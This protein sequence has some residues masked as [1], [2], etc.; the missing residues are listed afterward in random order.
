M[1]TPPVRVLIVDDSATIRRLLRATIAT[2][3]RLEVVG[4]ASDPYEARELIKALDPDVLTLDVEM[5][6]MNGLDFLEKLMRLRPMPVVVVSTRTRDKTAEAL[7]ALALGAVDSVDVSRLQV[8]VGVRRR[9]LGTL[10]AAGS[11]SVHN[12]GAARGS[13][14]TPAPEPGF[15]WN[16]LAVAIGSSTGGVDALERVLGNFPADCPPTLIAQHMPAPFLESFARRLDGLVAPTVAIAQAGEELRPG[17]VLLSGGGT[18]HL[19][20]AGGQPA[21]A[22]VPSDPD[23][24]YVPSIDRLFHS[25]AALGRRAVGVILTGMGRDGAEGL[26]AMRTAG[27]RTLAQSAETCV[28]DG[29]PRAARDL[30]AAERSVPLDTIGAEILKL[31]SHMEANTP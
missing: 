9:L 1:M 30:G 29:M 24:L 21:T 8:E 13:A 7:R 6:R 28:I 26:L 17:R 10:L 4:E 16:G 23:D 12:I 14:S 20:V 3:R 22:L 18:H 27:A 11:A 19:V 5:P 25:A 15:A 31:C 2:D